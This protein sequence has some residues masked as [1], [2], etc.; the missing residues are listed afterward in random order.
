ML[1]SLCIMH[2]LDKHVVIADAILVKRCHDVLRMKIIANKKGRCSSSLLTIWNK[3]IDLWQNSR[4]SVAA[5][6]IHTTFVT[7][8]KLLCRNQCHEG[9]TTF[10][11][12]L[13]Y[14]KHSYRFCGR[15]SLLVWHT[16]ELYVV[17]VLDGGAPTLLHGWE[18]P[19]N[20]KVCQKMQAFAQ[21]VY[22]QK[23]WWKESASSFQEGRSFATT[24]HRYTL[25]PM[26][27][28]GTHASVPTFCMDIFWESKRW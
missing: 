26:Y 21:Q 14:T 5:F 10:K 7:A 25:N 13:Q 27:L 22:S 20:S 6:L 9:G 3:C 8:V 28:W 15:L 16:V 24:S 11:K 18:L 2:E 19:T 17:E 4:K 23:E 1:H 12:C